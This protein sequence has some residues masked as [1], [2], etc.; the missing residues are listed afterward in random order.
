[1]SIDDR[2]SGS[3]L[4]RS[5][6]LAAA[7]SIVP[8]LAHAQDAPVVAAAAIPTAECARATGLSSVQHRIVDTAAQGI[9]PLRHFIWRTRAIHQ[10]DLLD[11]VA[12]L[13]QRRTL[14]AACERRS[15]SIDPA[16]E[17]R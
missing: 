6:P 1:M 13:D 17:V 2:P 15:A 10:L 3:T 16:A 8:L 12:W 11:T 4:M 7:L 14:L 9:D 5:I